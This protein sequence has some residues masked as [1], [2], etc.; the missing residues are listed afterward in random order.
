VVAD[1]GP[2]IYHNGV[3][4]VT[5]KVFLQLGFCFILPLDDE[6]VDAC[7]DPGA[8]FLG[9]Y[10]HVGEAKSYKLTGC[11]LTDAEA[12]LNSH[13]CVPL[14]AISLLADKSGHGFSITFEFGL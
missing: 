12:I 11:H 9:V 3:P 10:A 5:F 8:G 2:L 7:G 14:I 13:S 1:G 6:V 4:F